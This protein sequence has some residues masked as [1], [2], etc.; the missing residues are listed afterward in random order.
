M[1]RCFAEG[2]KEWEEGEF[3]GKRIISAPID[4]FLPMPGKTNE[5]SDAKISQPVGRRANRSLNGKKSR[6]RESIWEEENSYFHAHFSFHRGE[7]SIRS[8]RRGIQRILIDAQYKNFSPNNR[9]LILIVNIIIGKYFSFQS[10]Y[11][12]NVQFSIFELYLFY[13]YSFTIQDWGG[14]LSI[15]HY[16]K[17]TKFE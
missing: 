8:D 9:T 16:N 3:S 13:H 15:K 14:F 1:D 5:E 7:R 6:G 11:H 17:L 2:E 4:A 12:S 10:Y